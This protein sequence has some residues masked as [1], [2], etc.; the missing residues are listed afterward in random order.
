[1]KILIQINQDFEQ[2]IIIEEGFIKNREAIIATGSNNSSRYF[3]YYFRSYPHIIRKN[4]NSAAVISGSE[5]N[6]EL[7]KLADDIFSFFGMG[8]RNVSKVFLPEGFKIPD[9]L[10][11]FEHYSYLGN[12]NKYANN[13]EYHRAIHLINSTFFYDMGFLIC[14]EDNTYSSPVGTIYYEFYSSKENI[15]RKLEND[16]E[17]LQCVIATEDFYPGTIEFG[18]SQFPML[19]DYADNVDCMEFLINLNR[20]NSL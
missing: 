14:K 11:H 20:E 19:W 12:H 9:L 1:M 2:L 13:Y 7:A 8:C 18:N 17:L 15:K 6:I 16:K 4:R 10:K 3:D 5:T